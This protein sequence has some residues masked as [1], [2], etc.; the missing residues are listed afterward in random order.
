MTVWRGR[1]VRFRGGGYRGLTCGV[2]T[3]VTLNFH[4]Y[5]TIKFTSML[6]AVMGDI[7]QRGL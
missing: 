6:G 7:F 2:R 4:R 3:Y 1:V 5:F